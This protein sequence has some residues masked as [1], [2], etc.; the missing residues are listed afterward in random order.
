MNMNMIGHGYKTLKNFLSLDIV[1][2]W[3]IAK[4]YHI[5]VFKG[6]SNK[7]YVFLTFYGELSFIILVW[8]NLK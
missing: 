7:I 2:P 4:I 1:T 5:L 3:R 8:Y 6:K